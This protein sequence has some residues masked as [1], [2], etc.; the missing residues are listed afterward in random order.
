MNPYCEVEIDGSWVCVLC[1]AHNPPICD[2]K[3]VG[4]VSDRASVRN[5]LKFHCKELQS[6]PGPP[7]G[8]FVSTFAIENSA[9][10][11]ATSFVSGGM[12]TVTYVLAVDA[13]IVCGKD[14]ESEVRELLLPALAA[15][16]D[17]AHKASVIIVVLHEAH[18]SILRLNEYC[19]DHRSSS[20]L[21][22]PLNVY[23]GSPLVD[24]AGTSST[25]AVDICPALS[26]SSAVSRCFKGAGRG[27][28]SYILP[29]DQSHL[30]THLFSQSLYAV[31]KDDAVV[32]FETILATVRSVAAGSRGSAGGLLCSV[33]A[34]V[35]LVN[36]V[37]S[38][39]AQSDSA[40]AIRLIMLVGSPPS[41]CVNEPP[42]RSLASL[43]TKDLE[44]ENVLERS[45]QQA[46]DELAFLY[47]YECLGRLALERNNCFIDLFYAN[48]AIIDNTTGL[49]HLV[50]VSGGQLVTAERISDPAFMAAFVAC[51]GLPSSCFQR[52]KQPCREMVGALV[53]YTTSSNLRPAT[54]PDGSSVPVKHGRVLARAGA[55]AGAGELLAG[56]K[57]VGGDVALG[58]VPAL[59]GGADATAASDARR[60]L[61]ARTREH[62][63]ATVNRAND[64]AGRKVVTADAADSVDKLR[65]CAQDCLVHWDR[66]L[67]A[68]DKESGKA[69]LAAGGSFV[70]ALDMLAQ[71]REDLGSDAEEGDDCEVD[72]A[73]AFSGS[74]GGVGDGSSTVGAHCGKF[75]QEL[76]SSARRIP[77]ASF[78]VLLRPRRVLQ[79]LASNDK[80]VPTIGDDLDE[81]EG[82]STTRAGA[83]DGPRAHSCF[84][85]VQCSVSYLV[86]R[87]VVV[88]KTFTN[89][90][91]IKYPV[92]VANSGPPKLGA[93]DDCTGLPLALLLTRHLVHQ[94]AADVLL[95]PL[96]QCDYYHSANTIANKNGKTSSGLSVSFNNF[97]LRHT[98]EHYCGLVDKFIQQQKVVVGA[99]WK[100]QSVDSIR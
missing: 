60:L 7:G 75:F 5:H 93:G 35:G 25:I 100:T 80:R 83:E 6:P 82:G 19:T 70:G 78:S 91:R 94:Y 59:V 62:I 64:A 79:L 27:N 65:A 85:Y 15:I 87:G 14:K 38:H 16:D 41:A 42:R 68:Q 55:P 56:S 39:S 20:R 57:I 96:L 63:L 47:D 92:V 98:R 21:T 86:L 50:Q 13:G 37:Y 29:N 23:Y 84:G 74:N 11:S 72:F 81:I 61:A 51:L 48:D 89:R 53:R 26:D 22:A 52:L 46:R 1:N 12:E 34:A 30:L 88:T 28:G 4:I 58:N 49:Q 77:N 9:A 66:K 31:S 10:P 43:G 71:L 32:H 95:A 17:E 18:L 76:A 67:I 33:S 45:R 97:L 90:V 36:T 40:A 73:G 69:K 24:A 2:M 8:G 54:F 99:L 3:S 44:P